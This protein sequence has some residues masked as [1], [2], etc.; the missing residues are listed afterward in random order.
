M[1]KLS[2]CS[3]VVKWIISAAAIV[4]ALTVLSG[5]AVWAADTR[6]MTI[7]AANEITL[8]NQLHQVNREMAKIE[9]KI[10]NGTATGDEKSWYVWLKTDKARIEQALQ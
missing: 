8:Q 6:Y 7:V 10:S 5:A 3:N 1:I 4:S 2:E 9:I